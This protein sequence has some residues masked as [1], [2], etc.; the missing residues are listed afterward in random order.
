[1]IYLHCDCKKIGAASY[2]VISVS[3][4][5]FLVLIGIKLEAMIKP[6]A[7]DRV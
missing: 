3:D 7:T 1:M 6:I 2:L 4:N 5:M